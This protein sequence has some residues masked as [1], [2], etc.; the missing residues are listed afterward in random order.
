MPPYLYIAS[1]DGYLYCLNEDTG[2]EAWRYSTGYAIDSSPAIVGD[3]AYVASVEPAIHALDAKTGKEQWTTPGASHFAARGKE[4][5]YASDRFGNLLVLDSK[6]GNPVSRMAVAEGASTLVNDQTD[7]IF[8]V[9]DSGLVQ[10]LHEIGADA[11]T[12]YRQPDAPPAAPGAEAS[13]APAEEGEEPATDAEADA[14][15]PSPFEMEDGAAA[16]EAPADEPAD[17]PADDDNPFGIEE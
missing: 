16:D 10:C 2:N 12:L 9:S 13:A 3:M 7:R 6:T 15:E 8:L 17:A 5:V 4:R 1:Q 14:D 11:P